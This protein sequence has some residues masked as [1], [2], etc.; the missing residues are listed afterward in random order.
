MKVKQEKSRY[1]LLVGILSLIIAGAV[2]AYQVYAA[3]VKSQ[4]SSEEKLTIRPIEGSISQEVIDNLGKRRQFSRAEME[5]PVVIATPTP[6]GVYTPTPTV[7]S[8]AAEVKQP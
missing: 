1:I 3:L 6:T 8:Q 2:L 4:L 5:M 7:A